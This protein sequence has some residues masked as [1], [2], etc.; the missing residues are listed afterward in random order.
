MYFLGYEFDVMA[1]SGAVCAFIKIIP[2]KMLVKSVIVAFIVKYIYKIKWNI[3]QQHE[4]EV[5]DT[6]ND[7]WC[8]N[9]M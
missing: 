6:V 2:R 5:S 3:N 1:V 8:S 9:Y 4:C 7:E